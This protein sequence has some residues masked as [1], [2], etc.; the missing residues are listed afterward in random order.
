VLPFHWERNLEVVEAFGTVLRERRLQAGLTKEPLAFEADIR[1]NHVSMLELG[2]NQPTLS[3]LFTLATALGCAP[4]D[5]L[6]KVEQRLAA[7][8]RVRKKK[9]VK[10]S[11]PNWMKDGR[12]QYRRSRHANVEL[13]VHMYA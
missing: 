1:R 12:P 11:T 2:Q 13:K 7:A 4:S 9:K 10:P 3:M 6:L 5:L 8:R